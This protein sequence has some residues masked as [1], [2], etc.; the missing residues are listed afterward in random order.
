MQ[1]T[2][3]RLSARLIYVQA[4]LKKKFVSC[5]AG[6]RNYG[7]SGGR[8]FSFFVLFFFCKRRTEI[9]LGEKKNRK[10]KK[11]TGNNIFFQWWPH[12]KHPQYFLTSRLRDFE[13]C[14]Q[15]YFLGVDLITKPTRGYY[16]FHIHCYI[17][18][19]HAS[20]LLCSKVV[21][22]LLTITLGLRIHGSKGQFKREK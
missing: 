2:L 18:Y 20:S 4:T 3:V 22:T 15:T 9:F 6:G 21:T 19:K 8:S 12:I 1:I 11:R 10:L 16:I 5:P 7:Y 14:F 13:F 17:Y